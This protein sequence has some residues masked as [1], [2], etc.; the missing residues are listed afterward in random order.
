[1]ID[2]AVEY[3][4]DSSLERERLAIQRGLDTYV[5]E[6]YL[7]EDAAAGTYVQGNKIAAVVTGER[8]N[9]RNFWSGKWTS[10]WSITV[11]GSE[12][13]IEGDIKIHAH[14]FEDGNVQLQSSKQFASTRLNY[15]GETE[16]TEKVVGHI[17]VCVMRRR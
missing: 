5:S 11:H 13:T 2:S 3:S 12:A 1:M 16:L 9:L 10:N 8:P 17:Q 15:H 4:A 6:K 7:C 14:Y